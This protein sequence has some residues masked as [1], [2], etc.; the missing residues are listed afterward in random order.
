MLDA[1][2]SPDDALRLAPN[3]DTAAYAK[4]YRRFGRIHIPGVLRN[5]DAVRIHQALAQRTPWDITVVQDRLV[6]D[7]KPDQQAQMSED[8]KRAFDSEVHKAAAQHYVG[9]YRT[10]RISDH[11][12]PYPG[13][14]PELQALSRFLNDREF[15]TFIQEIVGDRSIALADAQ[16]TCFWPG[17]FL[18][19]HTDVVDEK[20]RVTAYVLNLTPSWR[21][22]WGGL[23]GFI[24]PDNHVME[25]YR[26]A[27]N[28]LNLL[29]VA[30]LHY[31][32][33][34]AQFAPEKRYSV[35]GWLRRR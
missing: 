7:V 31:V 29:N 14:V 4:V 13:E 8:Q 17:D 23:L 15:L 16:A 19:P 35:T 3:H 11:G 25:S 6:Y 30:E 10:C 12:E 9:R 1:A 33:S 28:A 26:P 22:E 34:V 20:Q 27:W 2:S 24:G 18:H 5:E 32:S 21:I